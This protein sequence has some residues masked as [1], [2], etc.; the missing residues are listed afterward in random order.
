MSTDNGMSPNGLSVNGLSNNGLGTNGLGTNGLTSL[1]LSNAKFKNWFNSNPP[2]Y[3][4]M[5]MS[6][7]V[8]CAYPA[9]SSLTYTSSTGTTYTWNGRLGLTPDWNSGKRSSSLEQGLISAC[10][11]AHVNKFGVHMTISIRGLDARGTAIPVEATEATTFTEREAAFFG[12]L[13]TGDGAF[14]CNDR[15]NFSSAESSARACGIP[16]QASGMSAEC[17]PLVHV[18]NC[19]PNCTL[20]NNTGRYTSCTYGGKTY[21]PLTTKLRSADIYRCGDGVC[22]ISESCD[23]SKNGNG[24]SYNSCASDCGICP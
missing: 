13:F 15:A 14:V 9:G 12:N 22:Q 21:Q 24:T 10:L 23:T 5:V 17:P 6:Y 18:G 11:A 20:D 3:S 16:S 7:V 19:A 2:D 4:N 1:A 8:A